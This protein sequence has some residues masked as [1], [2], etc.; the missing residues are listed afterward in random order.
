VIPCYRQHAAIHAEVLREVFFVQMSSTT[1]AAGLVGSNGAT[2]GFAQKCASA[3]TRL[4][5]FQGATS[6]GAGTRLGQRLYSAEIQGG[7]QR[8]ASLISLYHNVCGG[9]FGGA[10]VVLLE[11]CLELPAWS[12]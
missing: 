7:E 11:C 10:S 3:G 12:V 6:N 4:A 9:E 8:A 2:S 5:F 1:A